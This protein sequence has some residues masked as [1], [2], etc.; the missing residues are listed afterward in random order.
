MHLSM[1]RLGQGLLFE[2][3]L[4]CEKRKCASALLRTSRMPM[5]IVHIFCCL[6]RDVARIRGLLHKY[7]SNHNI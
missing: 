6:G 4:K 2:K 7:Y 5:H 1:Q 3:K